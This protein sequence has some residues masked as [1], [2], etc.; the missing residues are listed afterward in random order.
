L[1]FN[2]CVLVFLWPLLVDRPWFAALLW[3]YEYSQESVVIL[4]DKEK[5]RGTIIADE[6]SSQRHGFYSVRTQ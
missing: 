6:A 1:G 3:E 5:A 2:A 4:M